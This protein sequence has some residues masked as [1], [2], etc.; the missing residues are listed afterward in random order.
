MEH[1]C[2]KLVLKHWF[3]GAGKRDAITG[4]VYSVCGGIGS[5][6]CSCKRIPIGIKDIR[7]A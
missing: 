5:D 2:L 6:V 3:L 7:M 4:P 1:V